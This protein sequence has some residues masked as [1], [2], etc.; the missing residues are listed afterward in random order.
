M[1]Q[2]D[3]DNPTAATPLAGVRVL[4]A[5]F[6]LAGPLVG[7]L[8]GDLGAEVIKVEPPTGDPSRGP[9][10]NHPD[11]EPND[12]WRALH[13]GTQSVVIDLKS[14]EGLSAMEELLRGV[15][16]FVENLR[17]GVMRR[18]GLGWDRVREVNPSLV[19]CSL[20]GF[21]E[22]RG[23]G[24]TATDGVIQAFSGWVDETSDNGFDLGINP[25]LTV[26]D[27]ISGNFATHAVLAALFR[28]QSSGKGGLVELNMADVMVYARTLCHAPGLAPPS[29]F[30]AKTSDGN[31]ILVQTALHLADRMLRVLSEEPGFSQLAEDQRFKTKEGRAEHADEYL[32]SVRAA[33]ARRTQAEWL[34]LFGEAGVPATPIESPR[35]A[36]G[37]PLR[38]DGAAPATHS[39]IA[40]LGA[41]TEEVL[42]RAGYT[43]SQIA[44]MRGSAA[45]RGSDG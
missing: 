29:T 25:T 36:S 11:W 40:R 6:M 15:D 37:P 21:A 41:S 35:A 31:R 1:H 23:G 8:L 43:D 28:R 17:P 19:Y 44:A 26:A 16:V 33:I 24:M 9:A 39:E 32:A 27:F 3:C 18:L 30:I 4:D 14:P 7:R 22:D 5:G 34:R 42:R 45:V 38:F 13:G 10:A 20:R 2:G 12:F